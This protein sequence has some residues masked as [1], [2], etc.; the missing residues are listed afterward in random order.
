MMNLNEIRQDI[1]LVNAIDWHMT[2]EEAVVLY[3]EWGNN[4]AHG[5]NLIRSKNDVS[6]Y[7][8]VNN[9]G[10]NPIVYLIRRNSEEAVELA[11]FGLPEDIKERFKKSVA[12][13]KGVYAI[14]GEVKDWLQKEI[15][16]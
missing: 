11:K 1:N 3:L 6:H 16:N 12:Y 2:P 4:W 9:W 7:F 14:D 8:V 10:E 5:V 15:M 13:N